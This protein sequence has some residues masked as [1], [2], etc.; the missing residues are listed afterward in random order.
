MSFTKS[1]ILALPLFLV[2]CGGGG[3]DDGMSPDA[4]APGMVDAGTDPGEMVDARISATLCE[5]YCSKV[6]SNCLETETQYGSTGECVDTCTAAGWREGEVGDTSGNTLNCRLSHA[7]ALAAED[8]AQYCPIA[9]PTGGGVCGSL[10]QNYCFYTNDICGDQGYTSP[11]QC[12]EACDKLVDQDGGATEISGNTVQCRIN[13]ALS[14]SLETDGSNEKLSECAAASLSGGGVCGD[15]CETYCDFMEANCGGQGE[16]ISYADRNACLSTCAGFDADG[17]IDA[18][19]GDTVQCRM[20]FAGAPAL[21][22][23]ATFC[24]YA[25]E[26]PTN[27]CVEAD[28]G[29]GGGGP[30][31]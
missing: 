24:G 6:M 15:W 9:G 2:A 4:S 1:L 11:G 27:N 30:G 16:D 23:P 22:D 21:R 13:H 12:E 14:A 10:C 20:H 5:S 31:I 18:E 26:F 25:A 17:D 3:G 29:G 7:D 8:P 19:E 28:N